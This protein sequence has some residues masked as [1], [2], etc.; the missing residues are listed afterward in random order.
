M[1]ERDP[2]DEA[3][4]GHGT[5]YGGVGHP[6]EDPRIHGERHPVARM[7]A[8]GV[9]AA[10][11]GTGITLLIDWFPEDGDTAA[12]RIDTVYDVLLISS[13]PIFV[14]V[15][16]VAIYSVV[17][18]RAKPG[19]MSDGPPIHGN[20]RLE[21]I[22]V[23]IPFILVSALAIYGWI[24]LD[25]IEAKQ[26]DEMVVRVTG[27]QFAWSFEY[28]QQRVRS[29]ELVLPEDRPVLFGIR[30]RDV[31][32][33]FWVPEFRLKQDAVPGLTTHIRLT[34]DQVGRYQV[35]CAELCGLG[36]ATMRQL[37]RV[38]P[39]DAFDSWLARRRERA[40]GG[41]G[42]AG[43]AGGGQAAAGETVFTDNGCGSCHTL[44]EA[45]TNGTVGPNLDNISRPNRAYVEESIVDPNAEVAEGFR[46]GIMPATFE[47]RLSPEEL[48]ALVEYLLEAQQ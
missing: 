47:D 36:H 20:T 18:F 6:E 16:T 23:T 31:V 42:G 1:D 46:R 33:S 39:P 22:W 14:L 27:Q 9:L 12:S 38:V 30:S 40:A 43:G 15:M 5:E 26:P 32:H 24:V 2:Q 29:T 21:I 8:I 10:L 41:G 13:I 3:A 45:G 7:I 48:D 37:V 4:I 44:S 25:D 11:I 34:P 19:D 17:R 35:V 28:P